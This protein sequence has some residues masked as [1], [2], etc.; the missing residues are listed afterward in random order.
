MKKTKR[1]RLF[2]GVVSIPTLCIHRRKADK[3]GVSADYYISLLPF[4]LCVEYYSSAFATNYTHKRTNTE[5]VTEWMNVRRLIGIRNYPVIRQMD[6][7][8][9]PIFQWTIIYWNR[10]KSMGSEWIHF[11]ARDFELQTDFGNYQSYLVIV[12]KIW[13]CTDEPV[14]MWNGGIVNRIRRQLQCDS[15]FGEKSIGVSKRKY[16]CFDSFEN[17]RTIAVRKDEKKNLLIYI[18]FVIST[19]FDWKKCLSLKWLD[20]SCCISSLKVI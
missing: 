20:G 14:W 2:Y 5:S 11:N 16:H 10:R 6:F 12:Y 7:A 13:I 17:Y 1:I 8:W 18:D 3:N 4:L 15:L 9:A 19:G